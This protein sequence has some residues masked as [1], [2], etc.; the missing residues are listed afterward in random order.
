[1]VDS[2]LRNRRGLTLVEV[3]ISIFIGSLA[4]LGVVRLFSSSLRAYNLQEQL[5]GMY[6]NGTYTIKKIS[7]VLM[8]AGVDLPQ[9]NFAV[10]HVSS[11]RPDSFSIRLNPTGAVYVLPVTFMDSSNIH[12]PDSTSVAF[13]PCSLMVRDSLSID[14]LLSKY[15]ITSVDTGLLPTI[16]INSAGNFFLGSTIYGYNAIAYYKKGN[17]ICSNTDTLAENIDSFCVIFY[18]RSHTATTTTWDSMFTASIYVRTRTSQPDP[19]YKCPGFNDGY[20]RLP[21]STEVRFRNKS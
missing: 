1:V 20:R 18:D 16:H 10:L 2:Y 15:S 12:V 13:K 7:E 6:Q 5:T 21:M 3:L 4:V 9:Y 14:S 11:A 19:Q 17:V 8:Q